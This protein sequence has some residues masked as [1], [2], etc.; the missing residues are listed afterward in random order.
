MV[1]AIS[2][3]DLMCPT[4]WP[5]SVEIFFFFSFISE[6]H[7]TMSV[8]ISLCF[9]FFYF[10]FVLRR[11]GGWARPFLKCALILSWH[12]DCAL[13]PLFHYFMKKRLKCTWFRE[14]RGAKLRL[15]SKWNIFSS[16]CFVLCA[17][18]YKPHMFTEKSLIPA[19]HISSMGRAF[20][21]VR[22]EAFPSSHLSTLADISNPHVTFV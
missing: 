20:N 17:S 18:V 1:T 11:E 22:S 9:R 14:A 15:L 2:W 19:L 21:A 10:F 4:W 6:G 12:E 8:L 16:P 5:K 7:Q 3:E 13:E